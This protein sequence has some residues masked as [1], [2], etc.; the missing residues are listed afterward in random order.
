MSEETN[1]KANNKTLLGTILKTAPYFEFLE[2]SLT[3]ISVLMPFVFL[4]IGAF[5]QI[6]YLSKIGSGYIRFFSIS[7]LLSDSM[8]AIYIGIIGL[9]NSILGYYIFKVIFKFY[10][11]FSI[12]FKR[13]INLSSINTALIIAFFM[14]IVLVI[15]FIFNY[16]GIISLYYPSFIFIGIIVGFYL[17]WDKS[18]FIFFFIIVLVINFSRIYNIELGRLLDEYIL[19]KNDFINY[20]NIHKKYTNS[21]F[22]EKVIYFN[23]SFI[24]VELKKDSIVPYAYNPMIKY[25]IP[26]R[27]IEVLKFDSFFE[28]DRKE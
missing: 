18:F 6:Y 13:E 2:K 3:S 28:E 14:A 4:S 5:V 7:Q 24:F 11:H 1:G 20:S 23:D 10:R 9:I 25:Y 15:G 8:I 16:A 19:P 26:I 21:G 27:K 17:I 12:K 22:K